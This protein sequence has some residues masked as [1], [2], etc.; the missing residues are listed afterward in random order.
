MNNLY[1]TIII[2]RAVL[3]N[4]KIYI[5]HCVEI[6]KKS[7]SPSSK[8]ICRKLSHLKHK[9]VPKYKLYRRI[10]CINTSL[11]LDP[12][13]WKDRIAQHLTFKI[14]VCCCSLSLDKSF[15]ESIASSSEEMPTE[16][17][18]FSLS[19]SS[20]NTLTSVKSR[21]LQDFALAPSSRVRFDRGEIPVGELLFFFTF[22]TLLVFKERLLF[23][24]DTS[25]VNVAY[26]RVEVLAQFKQLIAERTLCLCNLWPSD[27]TT[28]ANTTLSVPVYAN[29]ALS[30]PHWIQKHKGLLIHYMSEMFYKIYSS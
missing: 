9:R 6:L 3:H 15:V 23:E 1:N 8:Q 19:T 25:L 20:V 14:A 17:I 10:L 21:H 16:G 2:V 22:F 30:L 26:T 28:S 13:L 7:K 11:S 18:K 27:P 29:N 4:M 12:L 5:L 24:W